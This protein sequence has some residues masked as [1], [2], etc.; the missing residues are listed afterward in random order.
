MAGQSAPRIHPLEHDAEKKR[1][2]LAYWRA[3]V[4]LILTLLGV[5]AFASL[6]ASTLFIEL[7][8]K[9][10]FGQVPLGFWMAHQ[11]T[12]YLFIVLIGVYIWR[13]EKLDRVHGNGGNPK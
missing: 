8:N 4:R 11:G 5:W 7:L 10:Q 13:V 12:I 9:V 2:D 6:G 3:N 1:R